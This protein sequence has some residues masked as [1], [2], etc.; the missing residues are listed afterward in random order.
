[1]TLINIFKHRKDEN[2]VPPVQIV[3]VQSSVG[4]LP[5]DKGLSLYRWAMYIKMQADI[6]A[7]QNAGRDQREIE[8]KFE[9]IQ[10]TFSTN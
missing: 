4:T 6:T 10:K 1:M 7:R 5:E 3:H 9:L 2:G 8:K